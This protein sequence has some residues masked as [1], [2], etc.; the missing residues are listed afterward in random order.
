MDLSKAGMKLLCR[1]DSASLSEYIFS[2]WIIYQ[3]KLIRADLFLLQKAVLWQNP[4]CCNLRTFV[5]I[6]IEPK[7]AYVEKKW[8]VSGMTIPEVGGVVVSKGSV[9]K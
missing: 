7:I 5:W 2:N 3:Q 6:K 1:A 8:Q 9:I 4:F